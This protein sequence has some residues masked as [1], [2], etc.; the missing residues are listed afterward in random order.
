MFFKK[1]RMFYWTVTRGNIGVWSRETM[2]TALLSAVSFHKQSRIYCDL[3]T[4]I[5]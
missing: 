3:A 1:K 5:W 4:I 2:A